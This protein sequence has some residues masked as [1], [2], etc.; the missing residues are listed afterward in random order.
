MGKQVSRCKEVQVQVD[1]RIEHLDHLI[2]I[3]LPFETGEQF[4]IAIPADI[5]PGN[6][7]LHNDGWVKIPEEIYILH[8]RDKADFNED[9]SGT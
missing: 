2:Y 6:I 4:D 5:S 9:S 1:Y 7:Q 8:A 3:R